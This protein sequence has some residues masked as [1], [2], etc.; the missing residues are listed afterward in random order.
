MTCSVR[1]LKTAYPEKYAIK[2]NTNYMH[3][4][5]HN[6]HLTDFEGGADII[7]K[8][9]T[10]L[11]VQGS[12]TSGLHMCN[13]YRLGLEEKLNLPIPQGLIMP[14]VHLSDVEK[15]R[16]SLVEGRYWI[17]MTG[18]RKQ[19]T[20][21]V[22]PYER[23]QE[24][25]KALP[26]ITFVQVGLAEHFA[27]GEIPVL[28][29]PNVINFI[30]RTEH[31]DTGI[32][33]LFNLYYH[34][35]GSMGLV[36]SQM[37]LAAAFKKPCVTV[38]G[39]REPVSFEAYN[40]HRYLHNQGAMRC[41]KF[42]DIT[43]SCWRTSLEGC[44][45][46]LES[47]YPKCLDMIL[48]SHV[49][50]AAKSYYVGGILAPLKEGARPIVHVSK[51][52]LPDAEVPVETAVAET[53]PVRAQVRAR[54]QP[55]F[56]M[57]CNAHGF[58]GGERSTIWIMGRMIQEGYKVQ[59]VPAKG[60][61]DDYRKAIPFV[62]I[63]GHLTSPCDIL[64]LYTNDM[65]FDFHEDRY[66]LFDQLQADRKIMVLNYKIGKA[67]DSM[68]TRGW[69]AYGFLNSTLRDSFLS[70]YTDAQTF[71]LPPPVDLKPFLAANPGSLNRT[72]HL[73]RHSS[74]GDRKFPGEINRII[75]QIREVDPNCKFSFMPAPS[76][77]DP[78]IPKIDKFRVN[79]ISVIDFLTRGT[80]FWYPLP[81]GYTDQG[82]RVLV[83]AMA[84]GLPVIADNRDGPKERVT[85]ETGWLCDT[86][87]Q[88]AEVIKNTNGKELAQK[89]AA[90][91]ERAR[92]H[93]DPEQWVSAIL[94]EG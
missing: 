22:W 83:E 81:E 78:D 60:I 21:K 23:W 76:D 69:D 62:D 41:G 84:V 15:N 10:G 34:C 86:H 90:A 54:N 72:M 43:R 17:I 20:S 66:Q 7:L 57:V 87:D 65:V 91:K 94:G 74:Q 39:A 79:E 64:M 77:L 61:S 29:G 32:R 88:Y 80:C 36:S 68:W 71:V 59:L 75:Q 27:T 53:A 47:G 55:V 73:V 58:G 12:N 85:D 37:H 14:D 46:R 45:N 16:P 44:Q 28:E 24:V 56:K 18:T 38:A 93:F 70:K 33:D 1:D 63:T 89:G 35:D 51:T 25:V 42:T 3:M 82:P 5:D 49:I 9:G 40:W 92:E 8:V 31:P 6:P 48:P 11:G 52:M 26:E 4:W 30:G 2:V 19:F 50:E 13:A 67:G